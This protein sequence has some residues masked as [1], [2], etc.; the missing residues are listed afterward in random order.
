MR[1]ARGMSGEN[2]CEIFSPECVGAQSAHVSGSQLH[3][4]AS[5]SADFLPESEHGSGY[6]REVDIPS[7]FHASEKWA[8][9]RALQGTRFM[10]VGRRQRTAL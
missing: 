2:G 6:K 4:V 8:A 9:F 7:S 10:P 3:C 5:Q 1:S